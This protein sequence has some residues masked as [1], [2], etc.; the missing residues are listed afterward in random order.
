MRGLTRSIF[1]KIFLGFFGL[2]VGFALLTSYFTYHELRIN[3]IN[4][5]TSRLLDLNQSLSYAIT[6]LIRREQPEKLNNYLRDYSQQTGIRITIIQKDG[7]V[8]AD[9]EEDPLKM[10]DHSNRPEIISAIDMGK[11]SSLRYSNTT[12]REM[13]YVART[14]SIN[15]N[16]YTLRTS[17]FLK[18]INRLMQSLNNALIKDTILLALLALAV[19]FYIARRLSLPVKKMAL[20][21][22]KVSEGDLSAKVDLR[23]NDDMSLLADNFNEMTE[24]YLL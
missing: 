4:N 1:G 6:D 18:D 12:K 13:L 16:S 8:I 24:I 19:S 9:T 10:D 7:R 14:I 5:L 15:S 3:T 23:S 2:I 20:A 17:M 21:A 22:K 11:G